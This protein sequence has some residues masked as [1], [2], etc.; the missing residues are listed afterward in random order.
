MLILSLDLLIGLEESLKLI[1]GY[2]L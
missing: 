1:R 2:E